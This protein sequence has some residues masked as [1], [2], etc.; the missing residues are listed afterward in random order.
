MNPG[1]LVIAQLTENLSLTTFRG[2]RG[3]YRDELKIKSFT[4]LDQFL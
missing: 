4:R 3:R 2:Y 1:T